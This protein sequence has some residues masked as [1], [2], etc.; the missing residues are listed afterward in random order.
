M[1]RHESK[2]TIIVECKVKNSYGLGVEKIFS[3][4]M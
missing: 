3:S 1:W 2:V 4:L